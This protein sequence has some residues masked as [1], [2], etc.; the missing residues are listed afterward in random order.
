MLP[1]TAENNARYVERLLKF[2]LWQ[3]GGYKLL[4]AG[5][6]AIAK[7]IR[8]IYF[9][10]G[11]RAFDHEFMGRKVYGRP[12]EVEACAWEDLPE[13]R[14]LSIPLGRNLDGCRIGFDL[15]GSD[16]KCAALVDA[17]VVFSEEVRWDPY[18]QSDPQYHYDGIR[19]TLRRV[20]EHL[21]RVDAIGGSAAGVYVNNEVRVASLFRGES[22]S[23]SAELASRGSPNS[24]NRGVVLR[25]IFLCLPPSR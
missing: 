20:A 19:E 14:E 23:G 15:G 18:F 1:H 16:R 12:M 9:P 2:L 11:A 8:K 3:R 22:R 4:I 13:S 25:V 10:G 7:Q 6:P 24:G 21:P 17:K 5:E